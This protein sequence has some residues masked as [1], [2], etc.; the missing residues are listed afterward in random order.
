MFGLLYALNDLEVLS[1][2]IT[3]NVS[4]SQ[5]CNDKLLNFIEII[6][7][8]TYGRLSLS[9]MVNT[10]RL[11]RQI[12]KLSINTIKI[13]LIIKNKNKYYRLNHLH[14]FIV[15]LKEINQI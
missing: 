14:I 5:S 15:L 3:L 7:I 9:I 2:P 13:R 4:F 12:G 8:Y 10:N 11:L 1:K 6:K